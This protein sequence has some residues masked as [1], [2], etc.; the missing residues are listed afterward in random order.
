LFNYLFARHHN[1]RFLL[2][3]EDTDRVRSA[4][5][6]TESI[7]ESL[8]WMGLKW[9]G[10]MIIQSRR[11]DR[12]KA[13]CFRLW[14]MKRAYPCFCTLE[15][16]RRKREIAEKN[17]GDTRYDGTCRG[18]EEEEVRKRIQ[19]GESHV[20]RFRVPEGETVFQDRVRERVQVS[21]DTLDDFV[22]LRSDGM[23]VYQA[24]VVVDDHDMGITHVIR[25]DDHLSNTPKQILLYQA[26]GW[27][28]PC[29][30]HVPMILGPDKKRLS[31]RYGATSVEAYR[32]AGYLPQALVN[33]LALLG[34]SPGDN[35]EIM[36]LDELV[37]SFSL[38]G[39]TKNPAVFDETKLVWL[40]GRIISGMDSVELVEK[41]APWLIDSGLTDEDFI[42]NNPQYM[43]R[44]VELL[45]DRIRKLK[46]FAEKGGY[47]FRDPDQYDDK[48]CKK[49][50]K[51]PESGI[52]LKTLL[53][54][55]KQTE[56][57]VE[58]LEKTVRKAA[59]EQQENAG[60]WIHPLRIALTGFGVS[61]GIFELAAVLGRD[62]VLRRIQNALKRLP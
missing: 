40:N 44:F 27:P 12:H 33:Y 49:H 26:A 41:A 62:S 18:L 9:D 51:V 4:E 60:Q 25:G 8:R 48:A 2:R 20:L 50:W 19:N 34:W 35:R 56:W 58:A 61:P 6:V 32:E 29:F 3:I 37:F 47:F 53:P 24:A 30:A 54:L 16:L 28:V 10:D 11:R 14:E 39:I 5:S 59:D 17:S 36:T 23:P 22:I 42:R 21:H 57:T 55:L 31:K 43:I 52:R 45:K 13:F 38:E 7:L 46:D 15:T 1:G